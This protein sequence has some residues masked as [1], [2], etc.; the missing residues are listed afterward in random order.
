MHL[1]NWYKQ[2]PG[3]PDADATHHSTTEAQVTLRA[4]QVK[5]LSKTRDQKAE[6]FKTLLF[7]H[8]LCAAAHTSSHLLHK[9]FPWTWKLQTADS[10]TQCT[11]K[12]SHYSQNL[13]QL[14]LPSDFL[15]FGT[16]VSTDIQG[17]GHYTEVMG[18]ANLSLLM[19]HL[20]PQV[21]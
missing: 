3:C 21:V 9:G 18:S 2:D 1:R 14:S 5:G 15:C 12:S 8:H 17:G 13:W 6:D 16:S 10:N 7:S 20:V 19:I 4:T 11:S